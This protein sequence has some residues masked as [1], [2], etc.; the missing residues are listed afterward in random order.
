ERGLGDGYYRYSDVERL[1]LSRRRHG[2]LLAQAR[3][4]GGRSDDS[5]RAGAQRRADGHAPTASARHDDSFGSGHAV[6]QRRVA[7]ILPLESPGAEYE[8]QG[9]LL[10][11]CR[12]RVLLQQP[13]KKRI[14]KQIY[15]NRELAIADV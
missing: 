11:Q 6:R 7:A 4:L 12:R 1:A 13:E 3:R 9:Q 10:G 15:K 5:P 14:K 8:S 2:S